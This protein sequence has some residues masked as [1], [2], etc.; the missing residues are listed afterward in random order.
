M[1]DVPSRSSPASSDRQHWPVRIYR[2][3]QEPG[4]DLS[5]MSTAEERLE[6]LV[7]LSE[8]MW[9]LSGRPLPSYS[10]SRLPVRVIR[11]S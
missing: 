11:S 9:L 8:R 6:M 5:S 1:T 2:L 4:D 3:G 7:V 10:R